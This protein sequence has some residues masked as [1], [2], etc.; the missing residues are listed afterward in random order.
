M[1]IASE[2]A[3]LPALSP[4]ELLSRADLAGQALVMTVI[5]ASDATSPH[6]AHLYF[7]KLTK[8]IPRFRRPLAA[9]LHWDRTV[10]VKMRRL[11]RDA[12]GAPIP[13]EWFD[14]Y[15]AGDRVMTHL[16][17]DEDKGGYVTLW[18][19]AVWQTTP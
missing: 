7:E 3:T 19:N 8:G 6:I 2:H 11:K 9:K 4:D 12:N 15:R 18:W 13:G 1:L 10:E 5:R 14:G 16:I 17:W